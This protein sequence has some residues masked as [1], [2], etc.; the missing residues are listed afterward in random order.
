MADRPHSSAR[1]GHRPHLLCATRSVRNRSVRNRSATPTLGFVRAARGSAAPVYPVYK[2]WTTEST[3]LTC[4]RRRNSSSVRTT[5]D[6]GGRTSRSSESIYRRHRARAPSSSTAAGA[7]RSA[8]GDSLKRNR[9][10]GSR[11]RSSPRA[12]G[13]TH[14]GWLTG[15]DSTCASQQ[16][17]YGN[18]G[19]NDNRLVNDCRMSARGR[20]L[21]SYSFTDRVGISLIVAWSGSIRRA[22]RVSSRC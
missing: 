12:R 16:S 17:G 11:R 9:E 10:I 20:R 22:V 6:V 2:E 5:A 8:A 21:A 18:V 15:S 1:R 7:G 14:R 3:H 13:K 4:R 19:R